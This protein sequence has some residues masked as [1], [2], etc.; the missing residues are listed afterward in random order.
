MTVA[1]VESFEIPTATP[2]LCN[3]DDQGQLLNW[4]YL[5]VNHHPARIA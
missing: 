4:Q 5:D 1:Q 2:I 3:F